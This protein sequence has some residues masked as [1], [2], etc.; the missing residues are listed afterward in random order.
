MARMMAT[1][2]NGG[3]IYPL[4]LIKVGSK[5]IGQLGFKPETIQTIKDALAGVVNEP[6]G[7]GH[8][9]Q[10]QA[11]LIAGK[12]GT[13][14]VVG[15]RRGVSA[16]KYMDHAWF[17]GFAPVDKPKI[18]VAVFVEHGVHGGTAA[19]PI[20]RRAIE[21]YLIKHKPA[22]AVAPPAAP[23]GGNPDVQQKK[24]DSPEVGE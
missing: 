9:A 11:V 2:A 1:F 13:A 20:A 4:S 15:K 7:T 21:A 5:P 22:K 14:Q 16:E 17:V 23:A 24:E 19:A 6:G 8:A 18:A 3:T 10:S 12:T